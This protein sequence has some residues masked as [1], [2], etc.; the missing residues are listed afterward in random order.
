MIE[1]L[2]LHETKKERVSDE[3]WE[4]RRMNVRALGIYMIWLLL[5]KPNREKE[6]E[7]EKNRKRKKENKETEGEKDLS[8]GE[9]LMMNDELTRENI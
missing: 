2:L 3:W 1:A 4:L 5:Y 6:K 9:R 7:S 8:S